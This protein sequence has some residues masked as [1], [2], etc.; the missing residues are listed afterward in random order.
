MLPSEAMIESFVDLAYRGLPLGRRVKLTQVRPGSAYLEMP[1]P[2]PVGTAIAIA[3]DEGHTIAATVA[4]IREQVAG[5]E[6]VPGMKV[7]PVLDGDKVKS[8]WSARVAL[9]AEEPPPER[10][11]TLRPRAA[12]IP[13]PP[14]EEPSQPVIAD[15]LR[16]VV[17]AAAVAPPAAAVPQGKATTIMPAIDQELLAQLTKGENIDLFKSGDHAIVDDGA[18]TV[19]MSAMDPAAL[20]LE[21]SG[22]MPRAE[23]DA[24]GGEGDKAKSPR[25][26]RSKK[27]L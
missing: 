23:T 18:R 17:E 24:D 1:A 22:S 9:P 8:W 15:A 6:T 26:R 25:R 16:Q 21:D 19:Q 3:T 14:R 7:V 12:T 2:M 10:A 20:G 27:K 5:A 13:E 11:V 4:G